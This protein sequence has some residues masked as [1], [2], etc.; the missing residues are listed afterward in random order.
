MC[1]QTN[2]V[3]EILRSGINPR[4][5]SAYLE[6][7]LNS[8]ISSLGLLVT[9][10]VPNSGQNHFHTGSSYQSHSPSECF[11]QQ[12]RKDNSFML[13]AST[14]LPFLFSHSFFPTWGR[15]LG[16]SLEE[17]Q[18]VVILHANSILICYCHT[19]LQ[20]D[21]TVTGGRDEKTVPCCKYPKNRS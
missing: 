17:K 21:N 9:S 20:V 16:I 5:L 11:I 18:K 10:L 3:L 7:S 1:I 15:S 6:Q 12:R 2:W 14:S 13:T 4:S 19:A 8:L